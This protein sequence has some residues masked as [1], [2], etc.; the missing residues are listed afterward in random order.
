MKKEK[1]G[2]FK[3]LFLVVTDFR[4]YPFLV[5]HEKFHK[6]IMYLFKLTLILSL[7]LTLNVLIKINDAF[8]SI[9][10]NYDETIPEFE[11]SNNKLNVYEKYSQ[12]VNSET[13]LVINTDYTYDEYIET[14]EYSTLVIYDSK[15]LVNSDMIILELNSESHEIPFENLQYEMNKQTL[16]EELL[17][18][19]ND[20]NYKIYFSIVMFVSIA[21]SYFVTALFKVIFLSFIISIICAMTGVHLNFSNYT[22]IA[23]YSYTLPLIIEILAICLVGAGKDYTYYATLLLTYVYII[24]AVRAIRLDAFIMLFSRKGNVK[25]TSGSF[26]E[27]LKKYNEQIGNNDED[28]NIE[29]PK[30]KKVDAEN[31]KQESEKEKNQNNDE[32]SE[33]EK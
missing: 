3:K 4:T 10:D 8:Q 23:I 29:K 31:D 21:I 7:I 13:Y 33:N 25:H 24:Y 2:F 28:E 32:E 9:M 20:N 17:E 5:K 11:L 16:Y 26:E 6:S 19:S 27:E 22:K 1:L 12:K 14:K 30:D 15:I 18:F